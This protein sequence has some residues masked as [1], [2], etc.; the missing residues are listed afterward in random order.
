MIGEEAEFEKKIVRGV[1]NFKQVVL[2]GRGASLQTWALT[3]A[4]IRAEE[5]CQRWMRELGVIFREVTADSVRMF[6]VREML[7]TLRPKE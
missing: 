4:L 7:S 3:A 1:I 5:V 6:P 2:E